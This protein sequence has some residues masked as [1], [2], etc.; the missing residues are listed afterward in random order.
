MTHSFQTPLAE[1]N[2][3]QYTPLDNTNQ[4]ARTLLGWLPISDGA[5]AL[6][7]RQMNH[8]PNPEHVARCTAAR[9][10]VATRRSDIDQNNLFT[11]LPAEVA[12]YV[13]NLR[14]D[15]TGANVLASCGQVQIVDLARIC[16]AQPSVA[17]SSALER[18]SGL[19]SEDL[20]G[21]A[22]VTLPIPTNDPL[23]M[24]FDPAKNSWLVSSPN[25]NLRIAGGFNPSVGPGLVGLG[26]AVAI[27]KSYVQVAGLNGRYF[28]R[29]GY[30]RAYGLLASGIRYVPALVKD[31]SSFE[32]VGLPLQGMLPQ[33]AYLGDR[34]AL[35]SD[36]LNDRVS[37]DTTL[38]ITQK[39]I[40]IQ[41]LELNSLS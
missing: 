13:E 31:F 8:E 19:Q 18:V 17:V 32:E 21:I 6:A 33:A 16:A 9:E 39:M 7:G 22:T 27:Q 37:A 15:P 1:Q 40:V 30:H 4:R 28:L 36:F 34:P 5:F 10:A 12:E 24:S 2:A 11:P 26:F 23:P 14:L 20:V 38:P 3:L 41:A 35:L 25:P 29:D